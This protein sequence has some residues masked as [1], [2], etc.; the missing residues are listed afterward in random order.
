VDEA[1]FPGHWIFGL[2]A[3][4]VRDVVV[5]GDVVVRDRQLEL[6]GQDWLTDHARAEASR[7]WTRLDRIGEHPFDPR[8]AAVR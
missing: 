5:G 7:L 6:V 2:S 3:R 4:A 8:T 1:S